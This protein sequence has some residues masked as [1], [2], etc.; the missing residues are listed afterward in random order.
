MLMRE[1]KQE[2]ELTVHVMVVEEREDS[3]P[4]PI[5]VFPGPDLERRHQYPQ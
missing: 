5:L 2:F 4:K 1:R 3:E